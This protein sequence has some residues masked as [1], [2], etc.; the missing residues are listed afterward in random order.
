MGEFAATVSRF[1]NEVTALIQLICP[2]KH[3]REPP[4]DKPHREA[5]SLIQ[6]QILLALLFNAKIICP[7]SV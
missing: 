2:A 3:N 4:A 7:Y 1:G 6:D 5:S